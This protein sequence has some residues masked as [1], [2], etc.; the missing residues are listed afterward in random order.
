MSSTSSFSYVSVPLIGFS[1]ILVCTVVRSGVCT[2]LLA[3]LYSI[4]VLQVLIVG[5][6]HGKVKKFRSHSCSLSKVH[7]WKT[8]DRLFYSSL[9]LLSC[10]QL[11]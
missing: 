6:T 3:E 10:Q 5:V 7:A 8:E 11:A 2:F 9:L 4:V 1:F